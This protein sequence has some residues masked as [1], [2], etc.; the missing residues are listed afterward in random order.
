[1]PALRKH[2]KPMAVGVGAV[3]AAVVIALALTADGCQARMFSKKT[4]QRSAPAAKVVPT[5]G[6]QA[7]QGARRRELDELLSIK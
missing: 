7:E 2:V 1:M 5:S 4:A 3:A 6:V